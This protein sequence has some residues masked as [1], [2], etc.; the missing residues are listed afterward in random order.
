VSDAQAVTGSRTFHTHA[1]FFSDL[2]RALHPDLPPAE[3]RG[4]VQDPVT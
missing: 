2:L 1:A 4:G 3:A